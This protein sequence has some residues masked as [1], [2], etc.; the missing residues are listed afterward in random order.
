MVPG[1][2]AR[3][4]ARL[5]L[6]GDG[7]PCLPVRRIVVELEQIRAL[8]IDTLMELRPR[9]KPRERTFTILIRLLMLSAPALVVPVTIALT[10]PH[11]A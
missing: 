10:M 2:V 6:G 11:K 9:L 4:A 8:A 7:V 1:S 5:E 3:G